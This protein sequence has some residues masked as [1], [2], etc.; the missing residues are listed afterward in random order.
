M[1]TDDVSV[2]V[3]AGQIHAMIG[4]NGAGKTTLVGQIAG[5]IRPD[6]G[7]T[8]LMGRD[9]TA[10]SAAQRVRFG[11]A[12]S[13]Q[14]TTLISDIS[15][16][17]NMMLPLLRKRGHAFRVRQS[18]RWYDGLFS[19]AQRYLVRAG[20]RGDPERRVSNLSYGEQRLLE[21]AMTLALEPRIILLDEPMA[22]L[23]HAECQSMLE[24]LEGLKGSVAMLLV[25]HDMKAVFALADRVSVLVCGKVIASDK[26]SAIRQNAEVR[27]AYLGER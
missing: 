26:P 2:S 22:G 27:K 16:I 1:T 7:R 23:G 13:F 25:E 18:L 15:V 4:P 20:Y 6:A 5:E 19:D 11:L 9:V 21:L 24:T 17:E 14:I 3:A 10:L 8:Q 12:R